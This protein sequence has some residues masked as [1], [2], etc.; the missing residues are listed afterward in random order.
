MSNR[1]GRRA[2]RRG[3]ADPGEEAMMVALRKMRVKAG[4]TG[5][6]LLGG[7][8]VARFDRTV[9]ELERSVGRP[10]KEWKCGICLKLVK[11]FFY[12]KDH[13][14]K[15]EG[16]KAWTCTDC[17]RLVEVDGHA[18][19][20]VRPDVP[21]VYPPGH[22]RAGETIRGPKKRIKPYFPD[23]ITLYTH[24]RKEHD[25]MLSVMRTE[26][27]ERYQK[28]VDGE[29][30]EDIEERHPELNYEVI[31]EWHSAKGTRLRPNTDVHRIETILSHSPASATDW[32]QVK[33]YTVKWCNG[34]IDDR[35]GA[36]NGV[37][38]TTGGATSALS[39]WWR[40]NGST[41]DHPAFHYCDQAWFTRQGRDEVN[42]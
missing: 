13:I 31:L 8:S 2:S 7:N 37:F 21:T 18:F 1:V 25:I 14:A 12:F 22:E 24:L 11:N 40:T 16:G 3:Q 34:D 20:D 38:M 35:S 28:Y 23:F 32:T 4:M 9:Q 30:M 42:P 5:E 29:K 6:Q 41:F 36:K 15:H 17:E 27:E 39:Y 26:D 33:K 19:G 10:Q